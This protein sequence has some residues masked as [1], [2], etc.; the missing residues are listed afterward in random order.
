MISLSN[1]KEKTMKGNNKAMREALEKIAKCMDEILVRTELDS[2]IHR[3]ALEAQNLADGVL[4]EPTRNCDVGTP[5]EQLFRFRDYC[6][7]SRKKDCGWC[8][9]PPVNLMRCVLTWAQM[10]YTEGGAK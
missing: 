10:P 2:I 5:E 4:I 8:H 7:H 9:N 3:K 6:L 1:R